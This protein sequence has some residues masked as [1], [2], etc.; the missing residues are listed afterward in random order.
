MK[1]K[2]YQVEIKNRFTA[3]ESSDDDDDVDI[4]RAWGTIKENEKFQSKRV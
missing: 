3:L 1:K 4:S 2:Q